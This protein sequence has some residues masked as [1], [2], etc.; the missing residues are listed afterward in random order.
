MHDALGVFTSQPK[1]TAFVKSHLDPNYTVAR[2]LPVAAPVVTMANVTGG[3]VV[4]HK[5]RKRLKTEF[6]TVRPPRACNQLAPMDGSPDC[7]ELLR[8]LHPLYLC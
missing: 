3:K 6:G 2:D 4:V 1:L 5:L 8:V 7:A